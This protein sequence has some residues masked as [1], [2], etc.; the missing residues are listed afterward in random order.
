VSLLAV[1]AC[2]AAAPAQASPLT[3]ATRPFN[4]RTATPSDTETPAPTA[5]YLPTATATAT[6]QPTA[7]DSPTPNPVPCNLAAF[8]GNVTLPDLTSVIPGRTYIKTWTLRNIGTCTWNTN[9]SLV[10][11]SGDQLGPTTSV[12]LQYVIKPGSYINLSVPL[13]MPNPTKTTTYTSYWM[14]KSDSGEFFGIGENGNAAF[15]A[16]VMIFVH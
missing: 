2:S 7:T 14:L 15:W 10:F 4:R 12:H 11:I 6:P 13:V 1:T 8:A 3:Q 5:T 9:Y 16:K